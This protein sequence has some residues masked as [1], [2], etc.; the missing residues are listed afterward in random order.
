[1]DL[2]LKNTPDVQKF[3][4]LTG[5]AGDTISPTAA[6]LVLAGLPCRT[7]TITVEVGE[8]RYR[9][10][11]GAPGVAAGNGHQVIAGQSFSIGGTGVC[12][13]FTAYVVADATLAVSFGF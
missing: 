4:T 9:I 11:G 12:S 1:M 2:D 13:R 3:E 6:N 10:D 8:I 7:L 5:V